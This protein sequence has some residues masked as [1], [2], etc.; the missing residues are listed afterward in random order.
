MSTSLPPIPAVDAPRVGPDGRREAWGWVFTAVAGFVVGQIVAIV[1][2]T[3]GARIA[4]TPGGVSAISRETVPPVWFVCCTLVG[5]WVGFGG[6]AYVVTRSGR[7]VGLW[8]RPGDSLYVF[9]GFAL[10]LALVAGYSLLGVKG[11]SKP[12]N[13]LLGGGS[14]W[15]LWIPG[16]MT[17]LLAPLFEELYFRGVLLRSFL[18]L[19][20]TRRAA[21]VGASVAV[22][23]DGALF[24]AAHLGNDTWVQLPGLVFTGIV[25]AIL[26]VRTG[27]LGPSIVTHASFN[28]LAVLAFAFS[29]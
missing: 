23:V 26:A 11:V 19:F 20:D 2:A 15:L 14:G 8:F 22:L 6:A 5:L 25:L 29:R 7:H 13:H 16:L 12:V 1:L 17:V 18:V 27:R 28:A 21:W 4:G 24:G 9:A 3:I 10:Q